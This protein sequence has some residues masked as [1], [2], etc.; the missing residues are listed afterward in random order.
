VL[1]QLVGDALTARGL[2]VWRDQRE[3]S[4]FEG[5]TKSV[6]EG[7]AHSKAL[8]AIYTTTYPTRRACQWELTASFVA[9]QR[10]GDPR[11]RVLV[12]NPEDDAAHIEP[13]ELRDALFAKAPAIADAAGHKALAEA[14]AAHL[15]GLSGP[16]GELGAWP[17]PRWHGQHPVGAARFVGRVP[18]MWKVHSE[19]HAGDAIVITGARGRPLGQITGM[20]GIGKSLLAEE[21]AMRF[22]AGYP[23]GVFWMR[24]FGYDPSRAPSSEQVRAQERDEQLRSFAGEL[25]IDADGLSPQEVRSAL[26]GVLDDQAAPFLWI[27]DDLPEGLSVEELNTYLAPGRFGRTLVTTRSRDYSSIGAHVQI[28]GLGKEDAVELLTRHRS[29]DGP[30]ETAA[31]TG[32]VDDLGGHPLALDVAGGAL[33]AEAGLRSIAEYR[34]ALADPTQDELELAVELSSELPNGHERSIA[35]TLVRSIERLQ[36]DGR[37]FLRLA[38]VLATHPIPAQ[39]VGEVVAKRDLSDAEG[40]RQRAVRGM[41]EAEVLSLAENVGD[42][43]RG[44]HTLVSRALRFT[45]RDRRSLEDLRAAATEVLGD[46]IYDAVTRQV[47]AAEDLVVHARHLASPPDDVLGATL[48]HLVASH[49]D[50]RGLYESARAEYEQAIEFLRGE[51]GGDDLRTLTSQSRL[52]LVLGELGDWGAA[53]E[54]QEHV[55]ERRRHVLGADHP[56]TFT[57]LNN[58]AITLVAKGDLEASRTMLTEALTAVRELKGEEHP[59]TMAAIHNLACMLFRLGDLKAARVLHLRALELRL[60]VLG[61]DHPETLISMSNLVAVLYKEGEKAQARA[62]NNEV[63]TRRRRVLGDEHP[64]TVESAQLASAFRGSEIQAAADAYED[65]RKALGEE[66]PETLDSL[67]GFA[68]KLLLETDFEQARMVFEQV[69]QTRRRVFGEKDT[70]TLAA[71]SNLA[72]TLLA[73]GEVEAALDRQRQVVETMTQLLGDTHV[74]TLRVTS[75]LGAMLVEA[76]ELDEALHVHEHV[77]AARLR[78]FGENHPSTQSSRD[79]LDSVIRA[80]EREDQDGTTD[81]SGQRSQ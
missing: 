38:A 4:A 81:R 11:R 12:V 10:E 52:G 23:G 16:I 60:R 78:A 1:A 26:T 68:R 33:S 22:G 21:Y 28:G 9:G 55:L 39:L 46:H 43:R 80:R 35:A 50:E 62:L 27:V 2:R 51:V 57:S 66:A 69:V 47:A 77:H 40:A 5:I 79:H 65:C 73:M 25:K 72:A 7:L 67:E 29:P 17:G 59:H 41:R 36:P 42:G 54:L 58:L 61:E 53:R 37:D 8:V 63:V 64:A 44:V 34:A 6:A 19:L 76:G 20:G 15:A 48:L 31:I 74:D 18:D 75:N 24:A 49:D 32:L 13:V 70:T 56:D 71:I 3:I 45:D 14:V 30:E